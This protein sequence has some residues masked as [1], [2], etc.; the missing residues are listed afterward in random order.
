MITGVRLEEGK[1]SSL[2]YDMAGQRCFLSTQE[3]IKQAYPGTGD[4]FASVFLSC[5]LKKDDLESALH[6][7]TSV[8]HRAVRMAYEQNL[9]PREGLPIEAILAE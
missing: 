8:V 7:A 4:L 3:E 1:V 9:T 2:A 5:M 6:R